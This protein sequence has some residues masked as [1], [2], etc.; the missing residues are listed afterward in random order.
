VPAVRRCKQRRVDCQRPEHDG[1]RQFSRRLIGLRA[2][3]RKQ[4]CSKATI[5]AANADATPAES[6]LRSKPVSA[7][8]N[9]AYRTGKTAAK[10]RQYRRHILKSEPSH[11]VLAMGDRLVAGHRDRTD[12]GA[13]VH[14][15]PIGQAAKPGF[16]SAR[17]SRRSG[18]GAGSHGS[19]AD[20]KCPLD[21]PETLRRHRPAPCPRRPFTRRHGH[22]GRDP[23]Q[24]EPTAAS[25]RRRVSPSRPLPPIETAAGGS[26]KH[27]SNR[28]TNREP[29]GGTSALR[30]AASSHGCLEHA[31]DKAQQ[32]RLN[33]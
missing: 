4:R 5:I 6:S 25:I 26:R 14:R 16:P 17:R 9:D 12:R 30:Q 32:R 27:G 29:T 7:S 21:R 18:S 1:Q 23:I 11:A 3:P 19:R 13:L 10:Q 8:D 31:N 15:H 33:F 22:I 2:A 28:R 24:H 20:D